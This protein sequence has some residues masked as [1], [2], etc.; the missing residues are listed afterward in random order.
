MVITAY[1]ALPEFINDAIHII[2]EKFLVITILIIFTISFIPKIKK[3]EKYFDYLKIIL[4]LLFSTYLFYFLLIFAGRAPGHVLF[5]LH[6]STNIQVC[7]GVI[8]ILFLSISFISTKKL[9]IV[10]FYIIFTF[11]VVCYNFNL[12]KHICEIYDRGIN[13][14]LSYG[15]SEISEK[16]YIFERILLFYTSNNKNVV[17][18]K[19]YFGF[20]VNLNIYLENVYNIKNYD[21]NT[22]IYAN[23]EYAYNEYL[24]NGGEEIV[25]KQGTN[26]DFQ[27][28]KDIYTIK[29]IY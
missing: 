28:L 19:F 14:Y 18:P 17:L 24:K 6:N 25:E 8:Y 15:G 5:S 2:K 1:N 21:E 12:S 29:N 7:I 23:A 16:R 10:L 26:D 27:K 11:S 4:A 20:P 13:N 3:E 9:Y 22:T